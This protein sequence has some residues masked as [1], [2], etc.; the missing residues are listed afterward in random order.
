MICSIN[1]LLSDSGKHNVLYDPSSHDVTLIDFE[2]IHPCGEDVPSYFEDRAIFLDMTR[3]T[4]Y[5]SG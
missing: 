1:I 4:H 3:T 5:D 2:A